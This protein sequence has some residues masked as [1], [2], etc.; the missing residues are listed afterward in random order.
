MAT[1]LWMQRLEKVDSVK[2]T[3]TAVLI[4]N[5]LVCIYTETMMY[6]VSISKS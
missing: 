4:G 6:G 2:G 1:F 3:S 5:K